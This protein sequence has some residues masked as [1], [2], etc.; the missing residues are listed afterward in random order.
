[1]IRLQPLGGTSLDRAPVSAFG[2]KAVGFILDLFEILGTAFQ[3]VVAP[4]LKGEAKLDNIPDFAAVP[5]G[6]RF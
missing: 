6:P 1:M 2:S 3:Q 4:D 5:R